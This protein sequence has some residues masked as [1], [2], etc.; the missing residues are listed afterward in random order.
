MSDTSI[1]NQAR[2]TVAELALAARSGPVGPATILAYTARLQKLLVTLNAYE[3]M[4]DETAAETFDMLRARE[5]G[6]NAGTLVAF[7]TRP[8]M[9]T[10]TGG[11]AA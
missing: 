3:E 10:G 1:A 7:P 11:H 9:H 8:K 6:L 2:Q 4:A 5:A